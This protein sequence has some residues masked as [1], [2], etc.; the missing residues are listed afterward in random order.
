MIPIRSG[1]LKTKTIVLLH[2]PYSPHLTTSEFRLFP[3]LSRHLQSHRFLS[4]DEVKRASQSE[5]KV[6]A[7]NRFQKYFDYLYRG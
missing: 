3:K 4:A 1:L 5:L 7:K 6:M 2:S